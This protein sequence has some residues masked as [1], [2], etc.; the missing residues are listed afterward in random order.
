MTSD[1]PTAESSGEIT[2][3]DPAVQL[4]PFAAYKKLQEQAR[5]YRDPVTGF[6][7]VTGFED[8]WAIAQDAATYS[9]E[10]PVFGDRSLTPAHKEVNRLYEE[11]GY[12]AL[13]TLIN[14]DEPAHR[15]YRNLVD[16]S[17][18]ATRVKA[19][20]PKIRE[21]VT[22]LIDGFIGRGEAEFVDEFAML[23]PLY[24]IADTIGVSRDRA[25]D[26]KRWSDAMMKVFEP[27]ISGE[28]QIELT[29]VVIE[30]QQFFAAELARA[31]KAP[32]EDILGDL[33]VAEVEGRPLTTQEAV[34]LLSGILVAGNETTTSALG[35]AMRRLIVDPGLQD[36]LRADPA[37][38]ND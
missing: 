23:L 34:H 30:M 29:K 4:C 12:P 37:R 2:F 28:L 9:S 18:K 33:A 27:G 6:Y 32:Q 3:V 1:E 21:L 35:N 10:H 36:R 38:I 25:A 16:T 5:V 15:M 13:P 20:E 19:L 14:A 26:F 11:Q 17:F 24:V 7:E 31:R 8:L 22:K